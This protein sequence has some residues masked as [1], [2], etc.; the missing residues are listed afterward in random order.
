[1]GMSLTL[2]RPNYAAIDL[3][4]EPMLQIDQ[5]CQIED[6]TKEDE[7]FSAARPMYSP[8]P[9]FPEPISP[10]PLIAFIGKTTYNY[11]FETPVRVQ[12]ASHFDYR[13]KTKNRQILGGQ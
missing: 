13:W 3:S 12:R 7:L 5:T 2:E 10:T 11:I 8:A 4:E 1:M 9:I 6:I